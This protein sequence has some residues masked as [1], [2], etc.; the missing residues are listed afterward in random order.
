[1][2]AL[3]D[4]KLSRQIAAQEA[5]VRDQRQRLVWI[6]LTV[7]TYALDTLLLVL[8]AATGTVSGWL[9]VGYGGGALA[10]AA[11]GYALYRSGLNLKLRDPSAAAPLIGVAVALQLGVV[12]AAPQIAFPWLANLFTVF[13]FGMLWLTVRQSVAVWSIAA[14]ATAV[15]FAASGARLGLPASSAAELALVWLCFTAIL[16]RCLVLSMYA[17]EMRNK[18]ASSRSRLKASLAEIEELVSH[19]ELTRT[20]NRRA[21]MGRLEQERIRAERGGAGFSVALLDID[22]FKQVNDTYG[23][24]AGDAVLKAF[25]ATV[26][27]TMRATD[28]FG[29]Y[30][31]EEFLMLLTDTG[32]ADAVRAVERVR[33]AI[34]ARAWTDIAPQARITVSIGVASFQ[35]GETTGDVLRRADVALYRAKDSGRNVSVS[36]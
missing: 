34:A 36:A 10:A 22:H 27:A 21:L 2:A 7:G 32:P 30:G 33:G 29:R 9:A 1:M 35:R 23:H 5:R 25:A 3:D 13:A 6:G 11:A 4:D 17:S 24:A 8:F 14:A 28:V 16:G 18:L 20:F 15:L 31:G 19:D 26:H 12:A